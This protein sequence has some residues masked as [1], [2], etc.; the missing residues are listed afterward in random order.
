[1]KWALAALFMVG[2]VLV[3]AGLP[4]GQPQPDRAARFG[5]GVRVLPM[6][7]SHSSHFGKPCATCHHE[8]ADRTIGPT[9]MTCHVTDHR[10]APLLAA[11]FH[12]L[13]QSCHLDESAAGRPSG[14]TRRCIACHLDD[15]AF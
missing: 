8:F 14:P 4:M 5:G 10:V 7:F 3:V 1:M 13:C 11:Q 2:V 12:T 15:Q 6:T 9:C